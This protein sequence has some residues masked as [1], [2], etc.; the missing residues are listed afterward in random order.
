MAKKRTDIPVDTAAWVLFLHDRT[1]CVCR[2]ERRPVQVHHLD[3]DPS[4]HDV[5]N[6][7]VLCLD[8]H[9][10]TQI[11]GGFDRK[12]NAQQVILY[13]D[14]WL[15]I[16]AAQRA[17]RGNKR[18]G[19]ASTN[20]HGVE[21]ATSIAD[22]YLQNKQYELLAIHYNEIGNKG[23]RDKYIELALQNPAGDGTTEFLR[24]LQ[25]KAQAVS[26]QI[27]E[28]RLVTYEANGHFVEK[29]FLLESLGRH[30]EAAV[31]YVRGILQSLEEEDN[32]FSAA[33]Y[34]RR[35]VDSKFPEIL[36]NEARSAAQLAGDLWWEMRALQELGRD[37][38][39]KQLLLKNEA[40]INAS[41]N[42][43]LKIE[44][45]LAKGDEKQWLEL[46]KQLAASEDWQSISPEAYDR[47]GSAEDEND[48]GA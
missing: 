25:G 12:L 27:V 5:A 33:F 39:A 7:A 29:G 42:I 8:C 4:N 26:T 47:V 9:T 3:E 10:D 14:D 11:R 15:R 38:D 30:R 6:L 23:L 40:Q 35:L 17:S 22:I 48:G 31:A 36:Y 1:C 20:S 45:A 24:R 41:E 13:R 32:P 37:D 19:T 18:H 34:M 46:Q 21:F 28:R 44:L 43:E 2:K 16:V